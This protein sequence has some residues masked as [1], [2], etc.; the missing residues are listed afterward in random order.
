MALAML[1]STLGI[2][3]LLHWHPW[4]WAVVRE[5]A[6]EDLFQLLRLVA[7]SRQVLCP[8]A[9]AGMAAAGL[10]LQHVAVVLA[11]GGLEVARSGVMSLADMAALRP[12]QL[13]AL[14]AHAKNIGLVRDGVITV[15]RLQH[16][17]EGDLAKIFSDGGRSA[18]REGLITD[19]AQLT[20]L[21]GDLMPL[22]QSQGFHTAVQEGLLG[23]EDLAGLSQFHGATLLSDHGLEALREG[24]FKPSDLRRLDAGHLCA[25][26]SEAGLQSLRDGLITLQGGHGSLPSGN[27]IKAV[28]LHPLGMAAIREGVFTMEEVGQ[29]P[30]WQI[31]K[32]FEEACLSLLREGFLSLRQVASLGRAHLDSILSPAG[33]KVLRERLVSVEEV[34]KLERLHV[35]YLR[36]RGGYDAIASGKTTLSQLQA[37][38]FDELKG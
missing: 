9:L 38:N 32:V 36:A 5:M 22:L 18:L 4:V 28:L 19:L 20:P 2:W 27:H 31:P 16:V 14:L 23:V 35:Y 15:G 24:L 30:L 8:Q 11:C 7:G 34:A 3:S 21:D 26:F 13:G 12:C 37:S 1:E 33:V 17:P 10:S 29:L 6:T 25:L